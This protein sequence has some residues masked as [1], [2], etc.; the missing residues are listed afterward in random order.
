MDTTKLSSKGQVIIPKALRN[1]HHWETG[2][3]LVVTDTGDGILLRPRIPFAATELKDVAAALK[4]R[5]QSNTD[6]Q[7][8]VALT[9]HARSKWRDC[10]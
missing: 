9:K 8:E 7:I 10:D 2:L 3:E 5:V 6:E 4:A 1:L